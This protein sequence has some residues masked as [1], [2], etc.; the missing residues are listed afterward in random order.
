MVFWAE[1][2]DHAAE[3]YLNALGLTTGAMSIDAIDF[4]IEEVDH[5]I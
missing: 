3:Q 1:N 2:E 5:G 4:R